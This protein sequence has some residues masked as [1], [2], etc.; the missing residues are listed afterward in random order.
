MFSLDRLRALAAVA[1][2]GSVA[3]AAQALHMTPSGVS[4]QLG[5]LERE[6]GHTL[7][8]PHGRSVRL[9]HAGR[10]LSRHAEQVLGQ[11]AAAESDLGDLDDQVLGPLRIGGV[12]SAVRTLL[13]HALADLTT[14][15][16][17]LLPTV[18]DGEVV[19]LMPRLLDGAL[20]VLL[21][22]SWANRPL[23]IPEGVTLRTLVDEEAKVAL[24]TRHPCHHHEAVD[25]AELPDTAWATCPPGTE[26]HE[27]LVQALRARGVEPDVRYFVAE[28]TAQYALVEQNLAAA[29]VPAMAGAVAPPGVRMIPTTPA[30]RR[31]ISVA[32]LT[33]NQS[34]PVRACVAALEAHAA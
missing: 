29:L 18:T 28:H 17:R 7:L 14:R 33:R 31:D 1:T 11:L 26:P 16:P 21:I 24:S 12:A 23:V 2:H 25:L 30:L 5:K 8:E 3:R 13:P 9:T 15:H 4:Q 10:V 32:W 6:A 34:P 22:E 27:A 19:D 20:D